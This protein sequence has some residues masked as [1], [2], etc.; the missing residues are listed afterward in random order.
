MKYENIIFDFDGTL[1]NSFKPIWQTT[2]FVLSQVNNLKIVKSVES[3]DEFFEV[4]SQGRDLFD[5]FGDIYGLPRDHED[6]KIPVKMH[7]ENSANFFTSEISFPGIL[8][9]LFELKKN[10]A[11]LFV[12]TNN[13]TTNVKSVFESFRPGL[14]EELFTDIADYY[15]VDSGRQK[16]DPQMLEVLIQKHNLNVEKTILVGDDEKDFKVG[17]AIEKL[18]VVG[19][20]WGK[21][22][23]K[24]LKTITPQPDFLVR[25]VEEL[26]ELVGETGK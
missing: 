23:F 18:K 22:D 24:K 25:D 16:P 26:G 14:F 10:G 15:S 8:D 13:I 19:V 11:K 21:Y 6:L 2:L 9:L 5:L 20:A 1:V 17:V 12:A 3:F 7:Q 4:H